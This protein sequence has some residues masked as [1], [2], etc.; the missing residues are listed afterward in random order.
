MIAEKTLA[1]LGWPTLVDH[2]A[3]RCATKRGAAAVGH[4][5]DD[6][7]AARERTQE[8]S[9][10]RGLVARGEPLPLGNIADIATAIERVR[11][12]A[13]LEAAELVAVA[14][15]GRA[16]ARVRSHLRT[17]AEVAPK[18]AARGAQLADL[19]HVFH[20]HDQADIPEP[21]EIGRAGAHLPERPRG[22]PRLRHDDGLIVLH[23]IP[24][25]DLSPDRA[26]SGIDPLTLRD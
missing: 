22:V 1:D 20:P 13:A 10:A 2:W 7:A 16:L 21:P 19:G 17:H 14:T 23:I 12:S 24:D 8:I 26:A 5:F 15:T 9:E 4:L 3:K 11:K 18:L 6:V 25:P